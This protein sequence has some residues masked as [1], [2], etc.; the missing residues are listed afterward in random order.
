VRRL[1]SFAGALGVRGLEAS[2][3]DGLRWC[4]PLA[5]APASRA[6]AALESDPRV[7]RTPFLTGVGVDALTVVLDANSRVSYL[8]A[9]PQRALQRM[10]VVDGPDPAAALEALGLAALASAPDPDAIARDARA[11]AVARRSPA[12]I[13]RCWLDAEDWPPDEEALAALEDR[14]PPPVTWD[15]PSCI[16][17]ARDPATLALALREG[18]WCGRW[19]L[20]DPSP[21]THAGLSPD[22]DLTSG[23]A[24]F[25]F[26]RLYGVGRDP[27]GADYA[28]ILDPSVLARSWILDGD[29]WG[30][31]GALPSALSDQ[32]V[33]AALAR[34]ELPA[35]HEVV[36]P[37]YVPSSA[38]VRVECRDARAREALGGVPDLD[39]VISA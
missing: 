5:R 16:V 11:W 27:S 8:L 6:R 9:G 25:V 7:T 28:V 36:I 12:P 35:L 22:A 1:R 21:M 19:R 23:G 18:L 38:I 26:A 32:A 37:D 15:P 10:L 31:H 24:C 4:I 33:A 39:V 34:G 29:R 20:L 30:S 3:A 17:A 13:A 14:A 2:H